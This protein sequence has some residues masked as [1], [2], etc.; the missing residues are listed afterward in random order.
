MR[1]TELRL[2]T[3]SSQLALIQTRRVATLVERALPDVEV[4]LV[5][6]ASSGDR[7]LASPIAHLSEVG[8]FVRSLQRA[9]LDGRADAAVHSCKDLPTAGP[10]ELVEAAYPER[11]SPFDVLVGPPLE[12]LA[13]GSRVGTGSPRRIAQLRR[14]RPDLEPVEIRGNVPTR[15]RKVADGEVDAAVLA[16][17]GLDR[18]GLADRIGHR[19]TLDEMVPAPAQGVLVVETR[20]HREDLV[21][22]VDSPGVRRLV[23]VERRLL[24]VTGAGCRA[25]LGAFAEQEGRRIRLTAFVEDERGGRRVAL[26]GEDPEEVV[27]T[28][29]R[30]LG[31]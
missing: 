22:A 16:E 30:E 14:L 7:D 25:A 26:D 5:E 15:L 12:G 18:L 8:A 1:R 24:S 31:L 27:E 17:A 19:F 13:P 28:A 29:R 10:E 2:A 3:R 20:R 23:E 9:V 11:V 4:R 21:E 6:I